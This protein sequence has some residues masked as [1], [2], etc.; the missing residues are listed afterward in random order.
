MDWIFWL[1]YSSFNVRDCW[2]KDQIDLLKD[3]A[4]CTFIYIHTSMIDKKG[5]K[6]AILFLFFFFDCFCIH[7]KPFIDIKKKRKKKRWN[8]MNMLTWTIIMLGEK[9]YKSQ[10]LILWISLVYCRYRLYRS[11]EYMSPFSR[12][13]RVCNSIVYCLCTTHTHI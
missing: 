9:K 3:D 8:F 7:L 1:F 10:F 4:K 5:G 11:V 2:F 12:V 13:C 6:K